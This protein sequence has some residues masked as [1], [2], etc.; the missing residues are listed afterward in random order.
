MISDLLFPKGPT[1]VAEL[2]DSSDR[3]ISFL[4]CRQRRA[5]LQ[6]CIFIRGNN[7]STASVMHSL[8]TIGRIVGPI[9]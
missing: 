9:S 1:F 4:E 2:L 8:S 3:P 6:F 5:F 7:L